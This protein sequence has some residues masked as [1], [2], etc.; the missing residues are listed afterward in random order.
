MVVVKPSAPPRP[1]PV[2][3][4]LGEEEL[5][6]E[7][8][9]AGIIA[10]TRAAA[11]GAVLAG[12]DGVGGLPV[13][14]L[15]AGDVTG[16][17]LVEL[18]SP[19]L[20][21]EDR[22]VVLEAAGEAGKEPAELVLRAATEPVDGV[23]LVVVH[24][25][26][27]RQKAL[28]GRLQKAGAVVHRCDKVT[29]QSDRVAF[30][31]EEFRAHGARV[32]GEVASLLVESV[33]SNLRELASAASQ[34]VADTGGKVDSASIRTYYSGIAEIS[35]FDVADAVVAGTK[36]AA[37]ESLRWARGRGVAHVLLADA[38]AE[39]LHGIARVGPLGNIDP[40]RSA[41]ELGMAPWKVK[42]AQA[43]ARGWN[44]RTVAEALRIAA[45]LN[46]AVK[47]GA[48]DADY[49]LES[50]VARI[51]DLRATGGR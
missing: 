40:F 41:G 48:A 45:D 47:G 37:L 28:A 36:G 20:F 39:S 4:V 51:A 42:K 29:K 7:R 17:D 46:A 15:R 38:I 33:G 22:V 19:S 16:A 5:L 9:V 12:R 50:A 23:V 11:G 27:G 24:S 44:R 25:G 3:L 2:H 21:A 14:R 26:G 1:A 34:L 18:L 30:V 31:R 49:A 32:S 6:V 8:A 43:Q 35:G 10:A 13:T